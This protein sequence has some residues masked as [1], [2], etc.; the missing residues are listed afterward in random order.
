MQPGLQAWNPATTVLGFPEETHIGDGTLIYTFRT[1]VP[2]TTQEKL[3]ARLVVLSRS[4]G[5]AN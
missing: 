3:F 1:P 5:N 4:S 2:V